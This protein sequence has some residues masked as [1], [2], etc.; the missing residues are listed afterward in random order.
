MKPLLYISGPYSAPTLIERERNINI[1]RKRMIDIVK[2]GAM[3]P[4]CPHTHTAGLEMHLP[5]VDW[6][7]WLYLDLRMLA[8]CDAIWVQ[9]PHESPTYSA[10]VALEVAWAQLAD[11]PII[12]E[13][14]VHRIIP[15][16]GM[17]REYRRPPA[18]NPLYRFAD[19]LQHS[20]ASASLQL[21]RDAI[22]Q[23]VDYGKIPDPESYKGSCLGGRP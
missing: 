4:V 22:R 15:G 9:M 11:M 7:E 12:V 17:F 21:A 19:E 1:A 18:Y 10:G 6:R 5:D 8:D 16:P 20:S 13:F 2:S 23:W 14:A 3:W